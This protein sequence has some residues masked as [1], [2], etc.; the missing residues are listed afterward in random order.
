MKIRNRIQ[1]ML[2]RKHYKNIKEKKNTRGPREETTKETEVKAIIAKKNCRGEE[3]CA[4]IKQFIGGSKNSE[5]W[6]V[7]KTL[8]GNTESKNLMGS[9]HSDEQNQIVSENRE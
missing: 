9:N 3:I 8:R 6:T 2:D 5:S 7:L 4:S 1:G